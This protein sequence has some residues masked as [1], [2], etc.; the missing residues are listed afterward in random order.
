[1]LH[2][3]NWSTNLGSAGRGGVGRGSPVRHSS[4]RI[5]CDS[6]SDAPDSSSR[7]AGKAAKG[8]E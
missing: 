3:E 8:A 2:K 4:I 5:L 6:A 7:P 1:M